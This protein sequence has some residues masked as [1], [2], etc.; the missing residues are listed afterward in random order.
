MSMHEFID[1][2][3]ATKVVDD[4]FGAREIGILF[5][6]SMMTQVDEI[7][8]AKHIKMHFVEF[9]EAI[10]RVADRV[11]TPQMLYGVNAQQV[12]QEN[13]EEPSARSSSYNY[14]I[15]LD[16]K[17][18]EYIKRMATLAMAD[19]FGYNFLKKFNTTQLL[20][21]SSK[22]TSIRFSKKLTGKG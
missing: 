16:I 3:T 15:S 20:G 1:L 14:E 11:V 2:V 10:A 9:L 4:N 5:N 17:L 6:L 8:K 21:G 18:Q 19:D 13:E 12:I 7:N 22:L